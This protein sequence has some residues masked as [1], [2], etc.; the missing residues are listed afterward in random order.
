MTQKII[1]DCD[2]TLGLPLKEVDD[3][4][5]LLYLLGVPEI[6]ICGITTT[7]GNGRIEQVLR[8]TQ[9]LVEALNIGIPVYKGEGKP[10]D[11]PDTSAAKFLVEMV[12]QSPGE[13]TLLATGP[14]GNLHAASLLDPDFFMKVKRIVC[15]GGYLKPMKLGYRN[16]HELNFSADP[17]AALAVLNAPC[18]VTVFPGSAC[19]DAPYQLKDIWSS[20]F[21]S[22]KMKSI[23]T[24][25][26]LAFGMYC[27]VS[28]FYL[29]D[30]LPAVFL[31]QPGFFETTDF[32]LH[33]TLT[34][35]KEG[36]LISGGSSDLPFITIGRGI[37]DRNGFLKCLEKAWR[38]T[39]HRHPL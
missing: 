29:W 35:M 13:I 39:L 2:N 21:W 10:D 32:P 14:L 17:K 22:L 38:A 15:M 4:L 37:T 20:D 26:L 7:F 16:L 11:K 3:G 34:D 19:L 24:Q 27:G 1:F 31:T 18:P 33:S 8:Q 6:E 28:V 25:W 36:M 23:L 9:K 30:L 12:N 5:T